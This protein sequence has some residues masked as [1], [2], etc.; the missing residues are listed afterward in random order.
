MS[1]IDRCKK[2]QFINDLKEFIASATIQSMLSDP[3]LYTKDNIDHTNDYFI[4][5]FT[6]DYYKLHAVQQTCLIKNIH[7]KWGL[8]HSHTAKTNV[9]E[10]VH[11]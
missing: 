7:F 9:L 11:Y 1:K 3:M 8:L 4:A 2:T 6:D 5:E 10:D